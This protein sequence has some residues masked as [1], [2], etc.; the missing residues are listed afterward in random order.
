M[1]P[2]MGIE[3]QISAETLR[4]RLT[5][6]DCLYSLKRSI[7]VPLAAVASAQAVERASIATS[8]KIRAPGT[9]VPGR[10]KA[11][12]FRSGTAKEF[13]D[14]RHAERVLEIELRGHEFTRLVLQPDDP[15][16]EANR[17]R[18][19]IEGIEPPRATAAPEP[20]S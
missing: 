11:G 5:G 6:R 14:V 15:D 3:L 1:L 10:I 17:I 8:A 7:S 19:A 4:V 18:E 12:T 2:G 9:S 16:R 13:W 20:P